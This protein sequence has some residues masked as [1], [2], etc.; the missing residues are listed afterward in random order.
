MTVAHVTHRLQGLLR[1]TRLAGSGDG[2][3]QL[4]EG[5][6]HGRYEQVAAADNVVRTARRGPDRGVGRSRVDEAPLQHARH[7]AVLPSPT[8]PKLSLTLPSLA[9]G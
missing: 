3:G 8:V 4:F 9:R 6:K 1:P 7:S 2:E 5:E